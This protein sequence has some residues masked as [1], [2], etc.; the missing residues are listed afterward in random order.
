M[1]QRQSFVSKLATV[2]GSALSHVCPARTER[3]TGLAAKLFW[4]DRT[5][6]IGCKFCGAISVR[7]RRDGTLPR[8]AELDAPQR[9]GRRLS[10]TRLGERAYLSSQKSL[11]RSGDSSV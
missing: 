11:N 6:D 10:L 8:R 9:G 2:F 7:V 1:G 4:G 3:R 5:L